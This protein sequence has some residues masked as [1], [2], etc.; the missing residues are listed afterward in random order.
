MITSSLSL[1]LELT[2]ESLDRGDDENSD[3]ESEPNEL[4]LKE[5]VSLRDHMPLRSSLSKSLSSSSSL[6][7]ELSGSSLFSVSRLILNGMSYLKLKIN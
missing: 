1:E 6:S 5:D 7:D 4:S 3:I 2:M